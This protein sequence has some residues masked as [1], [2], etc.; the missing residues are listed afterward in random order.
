M[1]TQDWS[2]LG[3]ADPAAAARL[4]TEIKR[5]IASTSDPLEKALLLLGEETCH[6]LLGQIAEARQSIS[7]ARQ[8]APGTNPFF[9]MHA[10]FH[11]ARLY[12]AED[13]FEESLDSFDEILAKY[14]EDLND[15]ENRYVY[16]EIQYRRG[17]ALERIERYAEALTL[18]RESESFELS[19]ED[20]RD[21][22]CHIGHCHHWLREDLALPYFLKARDLGISKNWIPSFHYD[23]GYVYYRLR[24]YR[25]AKQEFT[26]CEDQIRSGLPA[27]PAAQVYQ[28]L[29]Y[30]AQALGDRAESERYSAM[31]RPS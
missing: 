15:P 30:V 31:V 23:L 26:A 19:S 22:Y 17:I 16:E 2:A 6:S 24:N 8:I 10:D 1:K 5:D 11:E 20:R 3:S 14:R 9:Q 12:S 13:K 21:L 27:P 28:M 4:L 25:E 18:L 29:A 7:Q